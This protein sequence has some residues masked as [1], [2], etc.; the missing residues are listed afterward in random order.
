MRAS[1]RR[2][3]RSLQLAVVAAEMAWYIFT[4]TGPERHRCSRKLDA[5][6]ARPGQDTCPNCGQQMTMDPK[7]W[8]DPPAGIAECAKKNPWLA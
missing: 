5:V 2:I 7:P 3:A 1:A 6:P 8:P 4:C